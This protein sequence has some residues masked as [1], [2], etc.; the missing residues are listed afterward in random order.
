[1]RNQANS[2]APGSPWISA[3]L[4]KGALVGALI[5]SGPVVA[6]ERE[7]QSVESGRLESVSAAPLSVTIDGRVYVVNQE[8]HLRGRALTA[9]PEAVVSALR[10]VA[11]QDVGY[12]WYRE[13]GQQPVVQA[14]VPIPKER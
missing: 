13:P 1:M 7:Y 6:Q 5:L 2:R 11:G 8:T 9:A 4:A 3:A 10:A 12:S 14:I